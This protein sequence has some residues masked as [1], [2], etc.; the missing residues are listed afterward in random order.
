MRWIAKTYSLPALKGRQR[1]V[2]CL[3]IEIEASGLI[4]ARYSHD[5]R[6]RLL[7]QATAEL[8]N[9][10]G[11]NLV[12]IVAPAGT[13]GY[14][15]QLPA[16]PDSYTVDTTVG[17]V[18][19]LDIVPKYLHPEMIN[20]ALGKKQ[21]GALIDA[22]YRDCGEKT[23]VLFADR[24]LALG[25]KISTESGISICLDDMVIPEAKRK[26]IDKTNSEVSSL[27]GQFSEGLLSENE[28]YNKVV[29]KW[30]NTTNEVTK[31]LLD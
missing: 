23:T 7:R 4:D 11:D 18:L 22:S 26:L 21:L 15:G 9:I 6:L 25:F 20:K 27:E 29:D 1:I 24:L 30:L 5:R 28:K 31:A 14:K 13:L 2:A 8:R 10:Y 17:R 12:L 3:D 19:F 16:V